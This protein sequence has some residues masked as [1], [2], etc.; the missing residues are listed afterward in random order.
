MIG[1]CVGWADGWPCSPSRRPLQIGRTALHEAAYNGH[2]AMVEALLAR[3]AHLEAKNKVRTL[4]CRLTPSL[5][6]H[7]KGVFRVISGISRYF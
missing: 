7:S 3:G 1:G 4:P 5:L 6:H 2:V